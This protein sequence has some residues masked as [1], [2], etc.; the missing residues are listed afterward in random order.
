MRIDSQ[1]NYRKLK[2]K[3]NDNNRITT[4]IQ[5]KGKIMKKILIGIMLLILS[6]CLAT[7]ELHIPDKQWVVQQVELSESC[8][9]TFKLTMKNLY[10]D[11]CYVHTNQLF[12]P[13]DTIGI[14][15]INK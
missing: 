1:G 10:G 4:R 2:I 11:K 3:G 9:Y 8:E 13:L 7:Q 14:C 15:N 12:N 6:S 5:K